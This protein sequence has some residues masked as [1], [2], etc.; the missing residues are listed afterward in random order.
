MF[1]LVSFRNGAVN[2]AKLGIYLLLYFAIPSRLLISC[3]F[4]GWGAFQRSWTRC[5]SGF[6]PS[7]VNTCPKKFRVFV[8][9]LH[10]FSFRLNPLALSRRP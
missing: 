2:N 7:A 1:V 3:T 4:V 10:L 6:T 8:R 9:N 5:G